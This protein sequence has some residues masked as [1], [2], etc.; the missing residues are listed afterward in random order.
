MWSSTGL[1]LKAQQDLLAIWLHLEHA[2]LRLKTAL[3]PFVGMA[4]TPAD[5]F[6]SVRVAWIRVLGMTCCR[7]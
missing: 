3:K 2:L 6:S 7:P 5:S 4:E 1:L